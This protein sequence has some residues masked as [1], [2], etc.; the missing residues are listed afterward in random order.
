GTFHP[1]YAD[2]PGS[3]NGAVN[4]LDE[5]VYVLCRVEQVL[6]TRALQGFIGD[7]AYLYR[8][9]FYGNGRIGSG[10]HELAEFFNALLEFNT[11]MKGVGWGN[12]NFHFHREIAQR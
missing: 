7:V 4:L 8:I 6:G 11:Q 2:I 5:P 10:Y 1:I 9:I 3:A 12:F